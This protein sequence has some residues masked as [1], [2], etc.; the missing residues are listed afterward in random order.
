MS[1]YFPKMYLRNISIEEVDAALERNKKYLYILTN[2]K[3]S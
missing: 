1:E 3:P 2:G